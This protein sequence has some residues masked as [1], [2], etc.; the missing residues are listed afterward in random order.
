M[1][2]KLNIGDKVI[3]IGKIDLLKGRKGKIIDLINFYP[4]GIPK[5]NEPN[6]ADVEFE[7]GYIC[8]CVI[9]SLEAIK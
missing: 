1:T 4:S 5:T 3:Y 6:F 8:S 2:S 9:E 7:D